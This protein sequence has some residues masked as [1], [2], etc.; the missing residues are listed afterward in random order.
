MRSSLCIHP[1]ATNRAMQSTIQDLIQ[2]K[3]QD[4]GKPSAEAIKDAINDKYSNK[5]VPGVGLCI[6]LWDLLT[7]TEGLIGHGTG[8][9]N[10]NGMYLESTVLELFSEIKQSSFAWPSSAPSAERS[11]MGASR[12]PLLTV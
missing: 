12:A 7:A 2:I 5:I 10:V 3:P 11:S 6:A 1:M 4:F 9:V 8:L